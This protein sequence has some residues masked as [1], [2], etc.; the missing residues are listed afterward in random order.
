MLLYRTEVWALRRKEKRLFGNNIHG[1]VVADGDGVTLCERVRERGG[2]GE[3]ERSR[4]R[5]IYIMDR[6]EREE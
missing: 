5:E 4:G 6:G 1:D 2:G 3:E